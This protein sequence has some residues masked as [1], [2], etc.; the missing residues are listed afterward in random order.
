MRVRTKL[1]AVAFCPFRID[2]NLLAH[3]VL[4]HASHSHVINMNLLIL[5]ASATTQTK[6]NK[7]KTKTNFWP[8]KTLMTHRPATTIQFQI[9]TAQHRQHSINY[10]AN[11]LAFECDL[12]HIEWQHFPLPTDPNSF[13]YSLIY[14]RL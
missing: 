12:S 10:G 1:H 8:T 2:H 6:Q 7:K 11:C 9:H 4:P 13:S 5:W 3:C 14:F